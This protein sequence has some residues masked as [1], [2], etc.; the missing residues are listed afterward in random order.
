MHFWKL[1]E[2]IFL[3]FKSVINLFFVNESCILLQ[4]LARNSDIGLEKK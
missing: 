4:G 2:L 3:Y 1:V